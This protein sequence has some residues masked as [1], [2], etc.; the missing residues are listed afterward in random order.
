IV[1]ILFV[2]CNDDKSSETKTTEGLEKQDA[3]GSTNGDNVIT[4]KVNGETVNSIPMGIS[5]MV[6]GGRHLLNL[7]S[8]T[9]KQPKTINISATGFAPGT[10][11]FANAVAA[12]QSQGLFFYGSYSPNPQRDALDVYSIVGG[13]FIISSIDTVNNILNATF[14]LTVK[15][16]K[17]E[18]ITITDGKIINGKINPGVTYQ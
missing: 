6:A 7:V 13:E 5:R 16:V 15:N 3:A 4:F 8:D 18:V 1:A 9:R 10:Y 14:L 17:D 2:A 12:L 11:K